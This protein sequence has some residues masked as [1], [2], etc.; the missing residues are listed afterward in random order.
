MKISILSDLHID[1]SIPQKDPNRIKDYYI[2]DLF[3]DVLDPDPEVEVLVVAGDI[4]HHNAQDFKVLEIISRVFSYKKIF[5]VAGNH[6]C[7]HSSKHST[8]KRIT[9]FWNFKDPNGVIEVLNGN[10]IEYKGVRFGGGMGWYD[11]TYATKTLRHPANHNQMLDLWEYS[12]NDRHYIDGLTDYMQMFEVE[13]PKILDTYKD[14]DVMITH[15]N[16]TI[17][18]IGMDKKY[19]DILSSGFYAFDGEY[20]LADS[21][22]KYWIFGHQHDP[23]SYE[24]HGVKLLCNPFGYPS[25]ALTAKRCIIDIEV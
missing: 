25:E 18:R 4:G 10:V 1:F 17:R 12:M 16:P 9:E 8:A 22:A 24:V 11:G 2:S 15:I 19:R 5:I 14:C 21:S 3:H 20:L 7:Y 23:I 6:N 13:L